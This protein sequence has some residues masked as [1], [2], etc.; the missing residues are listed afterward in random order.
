MKLSEAQKQLLVNN[1]V[2]GLSP[3]EKERLLQ[4]KKYAK[5]TVANYLCDG[6]IVSGAVAGVL[7]ALALAFICWVVKQVTGKRPNWC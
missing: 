1:L 4:D 7:S 2:S 5:S 3:S 6:G